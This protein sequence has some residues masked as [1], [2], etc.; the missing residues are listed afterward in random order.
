MTAFEPQEVH[1]RPNGMVFWYNLLD[2]PIDVTFD[3]PTNVIEAPAILCTYFFWSFLPAPNC[4][5][6][7]FHTCIKLPPTAPDPGI[8]TASLTLKARRFRAVGAYTYRDA[9]TGATGRVVV[10]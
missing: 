3:D 1:I 4:A 9:S 7:N 10:E 2:H 8:P 6:G 5:P